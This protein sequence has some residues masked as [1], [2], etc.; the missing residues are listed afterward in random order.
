LA[1]V[2]SVLRRAA[3][4]FAVVTALVATLSACGTGPS[5]ANSAVIV[6]DYVVSV[7][8]VQDLVEKVAKEP[9]A[10]SLVDNHRLDLV[11]SEVVTQLVTHR[12]ITEVARE[13]NLRVDQEQ[14][15]A[16]REQDPLA[17]ELP[18]DGSVPADQL[19]PIL[20]N[21]ARGLDAYANDNLLLSELAEKYLGRVNATYNVAGF[22]TTDFDA[23]KT[24]AEKIAANPGDG[25][26]LMR[27]ASSE[28]MPPQLDTETGP[29]PL[30]LQLM[31][32]DNAVLIVNEPA[33]GQSAG[34]YFVVQV[35]STDVSS[36][37]SEEVDPS[38]VDPNQ[39]P[40]YGKYLLRQTALDSGIRVSP[41]YGDWNTAEMRVPPK[42][43]A[44]V[45]GM[46]LLPESE[47]P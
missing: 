1:T 3:A 16:L 47:K 22:P 33:T 12:L 37:P 27:D 6:G 20:V 21:R 18:T 29:G 43:E 17:Q 8:E 10:R 39:L 15:S 28:E 46:L 35:L 40:Q 24:L 32:P 25:E 31:V 19:V 42:A 13:E 2:T 9:A 14:L 30:A 5:Q 45:A 38:Q 44:D 26:S 4:P 34:G 41:R 36:S 23:A 11:G 7:D